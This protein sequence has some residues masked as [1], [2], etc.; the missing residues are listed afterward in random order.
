MTDFF[1]KVFLLFILCFPYICSTKKFHCT[2]DICRFMHCEVKRVCEYPNSYM[3]RKGGLCG[4]CDE[5]IVVRFK[6]EMCSAV[7]DQ[8]Y[9]PKIVCAAGLICDEYTLRCKKILP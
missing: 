6:G 9:P 8:M 2:P 1:K 5:C 3:K 4:C 7:I